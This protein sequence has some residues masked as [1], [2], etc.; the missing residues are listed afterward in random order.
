MSL[1][2][3]KSQ[4][5]D[6][7]LRALGHP[8]IQINVSS[9]QL[10]DRI[11]EALQKYCNYHH[12]GTTRGYLSHQITSTDIINKFITIPD[13]VI[14]VSKVFS[15][16][17]SSNGVFS[18]NYNL[19]MSALTSLND[20]S[21]SSGLAN[22]VA[23]M[24]NISLMQN[25]LSFAKI[26]DFNRHTDKIYINTDWSNTFAEGQFVVF[27][28][29]TAMNPAEYPQVY[30]D[31]WL[32]KYTT[33]LFKKQWGSNISKYDGVQLPGGVTLRGADIYQAADAE[34]KELDEKLITDFAPPM[35]MF[36][37]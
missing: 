16:G 22:Y 3:T 7:C 17:S 30:N 4:L 26:I 36:V 37:G 18:T 24:S 6:Y 33:A 5:K 2:S 27:E 11:D 25:I 10:D 28:I 1:P 29:Y 8:V 21:S 20:F 12:D 32:K 34:L 14:Y 35:G 19:E 13:A 23:Q 31:M 15:L 9:E